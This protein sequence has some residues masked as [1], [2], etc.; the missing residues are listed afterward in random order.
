M[1]GR[2]PLRMLI[3]AQELRADDVPV[4][5]AHITETSPGC[6]QKKVG[7]FILG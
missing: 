1:V 7:F 3:T 2:V 6:P 5:Y 4:A